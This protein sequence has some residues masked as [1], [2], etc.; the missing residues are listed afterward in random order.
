MKKC[1]LLFI[2]FLLFIPASLPANFI[3]ENSGYSF[4][5]TLDKPKKPKKK[6]HSKS[7]TSKK[8][9]FTYSGIT[10]TSFKKGKRHKKYKSYTSKFST[11]KYSKHTYS[12]NEFKSKT[13]TYKSTEKKKEIIGNYYDVP[14]FSKGSGRENKEYHYQEGYYRKDGTYV[15]GHYKSN[16][17]KTK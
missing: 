5:E 10:K 8:N 15:K 3:L 4:S 6:N 14:D 1:L 13:Y 2:T 7:Y 11:K 16:S 17:N 12:N 9:K